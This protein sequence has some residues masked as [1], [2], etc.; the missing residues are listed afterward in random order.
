MIWLSKFT[1]GDDRRIA[2]GLRDEIA[3][4]PQNWGEGQVGRLWASQIADCRIRS[5]NA[6]KKPKLY[7]QF[8]FR[9]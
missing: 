7:G 6:S 9:A 3:V 4:R 2:I 5:S 1:S 8:G